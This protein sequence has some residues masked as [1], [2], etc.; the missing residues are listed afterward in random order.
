M[1]ANSLSCELADGREAFTSCNHSGKSP[2]AALVR[3]MELDS[4]ATVS[5]HECDQKRDRDRA[6]TT[7]CEN[8]RCTTPLNNVQS[9]DTNKTTIHLYKFITTLNTTTNKP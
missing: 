9:L 4:D 3:A 6:C 5:E 1:R 8:M 7:V 2:T